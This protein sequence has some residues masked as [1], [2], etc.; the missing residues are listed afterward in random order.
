M[1]RLLLINPSGKRKG[2]GTLRSTNFP[3][4]NLPYLAAC[5]PRDYDV[6]LIDENI[7]RFEYRDADLVGITSFTA[8]AP[9][10]YQLARAYRERGVPVV[11][12]GIHAS[13]LPDEALRH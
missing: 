9:R 11:I 1:K 13:M 10:A 4:L 6:E 7:E 5:T 12:G 3:P 8:T 2:V